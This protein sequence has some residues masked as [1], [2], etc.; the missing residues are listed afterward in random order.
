MPVLGRY[1]AKV[2][3]RAWLKLPFVGADGYNISELM[4]IRAAMDTADYCIVHMPRARTFPSSLD[5]LT[6]ALSRVSIKGAYLEFGIASGKT[7]N[8]SAK[9]VSR[10]V[11]GFDS[12]EGLPEDWRTGF[13]KGAFGQKAPSVHANVQLHIGWFD[14]TLPEFV[15]INGELIAFLHVDCDLYSS[16]RE[17]FRRLGP[18]IVPGTV[19]VFD[20]YFNAP[21][22]REEEY[23]AFMEFIA[24]SKT[25]F[26]YIG[27]IR[28]G[29]QVAVKLL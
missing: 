13:E 21:E 19:I 15:E 16:T 14:K 10:T 8:H 26:E 2:I 12:F 28:T 27:Y 11:H 5:I 1:A 7:I 6:F 20:E 18:R 9:Q 24:E 3:Q 4:R 29:S 17:I 23:K 22:W 25:S